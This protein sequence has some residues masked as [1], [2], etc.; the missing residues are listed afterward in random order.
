[1]NAPIDPQAPTDPQSRRRHLVDVISQMSAEDISIPNPV[2]GLSIYRLTESS[3]DFCG[4]YE[5]SVCFILNGSKLVSTGGDV[6][7]YAENSYLITAIGMPMSGWARS[8]SATDP[9]IAML[10]RLDLELIRR[11]IVEYDMDHAVAPASGP[12]VGHLSERL[13]GLLHELILLDPDNP[14]FQFMH[15]HIQTEIFYRLLVTPQGRQLRDFAL[16]DTTSHRI[17]TA[18]NFIRDNYSSTLSVKQLADLSR[19]GVSTFH[20]HFKTLTG[21]SPGQL[22]QQIR[23]HHARAKLLSSERDIASVA[24]SVGYESQSQFSREF[25]RLF[26]HSPSEILKRTRANR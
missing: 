16:A 11:L 15:R 14:E 12:M 3:T 19:M 17:T 10:L 22:Q 5:P 24:L 1:M 23:L 18:V 20:N 4:V 6:I 9:Y 26:G 8:A 2:P 21:M 13:V 25:R 7:Q